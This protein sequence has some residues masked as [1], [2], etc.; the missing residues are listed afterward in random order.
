MNTSSRADR[1][2]QAILRALD[3]ATVEVV[4]RSAQHAGHAGASAAGQTHYDVT[5][6]SDAFGGM[7]RVARSRLIHQLLAPEFEAGLHALSL[8][9]QTSDEASG[10]RAPLR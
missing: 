8:R 7:S 5:V 9:L 3:R 10:E 4:D 1:L 6:I 2:H